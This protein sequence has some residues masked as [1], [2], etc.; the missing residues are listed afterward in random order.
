MANTLPRGLRN[1]NPG[2]LRRTADKWQGLSAQQTDK[3]FFQFREMKW[4]YRA[5]IK[6]LQTYIRERG[7][8]TVK[9]IITRW[10]PEHENNTQAYIL[11]VCNEMQVPTDYM[12]DAADKGTMCALAAAISAVENGRPA[13]MNDIYKGWEL[14]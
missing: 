7:C 5:L 3:D 14:L 8:K 11:W 6:T 1:C 9:E 10:A 4:G 2:N 13:N 12:P